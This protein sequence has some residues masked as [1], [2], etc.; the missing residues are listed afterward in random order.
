MMDSLLRCRVRSPLLLGSLVPGADDATLSSAAGA[1]SQSAA[2]LSASAVKNAKSGGWVHELVITTLKG[3][4]V[5]H[6]SSN[7]GGH[8]SVG[9]VRLTL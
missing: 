1:N 7:V 2:S 3:V 6:S 5:R 9:R 8:G 4:V